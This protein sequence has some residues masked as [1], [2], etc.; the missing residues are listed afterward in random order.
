MFLYSRLPYWVQ[1]L[2]P[3]IFY[4]TEKA[5]NYFPYTITE[6]TVRIRLF[7]C[8]VFYMLITFISSVPSSQSLT[9]TFKLVMRTTA[10]A[11]KT[12]V[13]KILPTTLSYSNLSFSRLL[14]T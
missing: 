3:K 9:F 10:V 13:H 5:W 8:N 6:Y 11:Q 7:K 14:S 2:I 1:A 4:V 12:Y